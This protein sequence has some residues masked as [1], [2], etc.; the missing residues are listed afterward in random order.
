[1]I[2]RLQVFLNPA[3][4][5]ALSLQLSRAYPHLAFVDDSVW[6]S[7]APPVRPG[8]RSCG[9]SFVFLWNQ[10]LAPALPSRARQDGRF[11]GP[12]LDPVI[13]L[14]RSRQRGDVLLSGSIA[15]SA[16]SQEMVSFVTGLWRL[17]KRWGVTKVRG[18]DPRTAETICARVPC[19]LLGPDAAASWSPENAHQL[20]ARSTENYFAPGG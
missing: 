11:D 19:Y 17:L 2:R 13:Q 20:K 7:P 5:D 6:I 16:E 15:A 3:D 14:V 10:A 9:S 12:I 8:I 4:E 18:V 1:M